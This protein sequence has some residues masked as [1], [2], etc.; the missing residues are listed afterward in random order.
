LVYDLNQILKDKDELSE[1]EDNADEVYV[2]LDQAEGS[3]FAQSNDD[4]QDL[5]KDDST[6]D[7][8]D[9]W[10]DTSFDGRTSYR[11]VTQK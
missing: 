7:G 9:S 1:E 6:D 3:S 4:G 11:I 2:T 8:S 5:D 10:E